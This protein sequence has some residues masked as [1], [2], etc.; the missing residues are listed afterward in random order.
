MESSNRQESPATREKETS[1][2]GLFSMTAEVWMGGTLLLGGRAVIE[3]F[4]EDKHVIRSR[5]FLFMH[6]LAKGARITTLMLEELQGRCQ[7]TNSYQS[8]IDLN[9]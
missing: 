3:S 5:S 2:F 4:A 1:L 9:I 6:I 7:N 8:Q